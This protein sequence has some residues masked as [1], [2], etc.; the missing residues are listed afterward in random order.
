MIGL[1]RYIQGYNFTTG[2]KDFH[3]D[4][5]HTYEIAHDK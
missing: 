2:L 1:I 4:F 5:T 3:F